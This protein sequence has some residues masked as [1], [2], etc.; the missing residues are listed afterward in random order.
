MSRS[1]IISLVLCLGVSA[2]LFGWLFSNEPLPLGSYANTAGTGDKK[3][4]KSAS[5][6]M[7]VSKNAG[8]KT[9]GPKSAEIKPAG[10]NQREVVFSV[11]RSKATALNDQPINIV[12]NPGSQKVQLQAGAGDLVVTAS[13][14][15]M[16][17][18]PSSKSELLGNYSRG[19]RFAHIRDQNGWALV[20]SLDNG[21]KGWMFKKY[22]N[23]GGG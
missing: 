19:S 16:R 22:M 3:P 1:T 6:K 11:S 2:A 8:T 13:G 17:S 18:E 9:T 12:I 4:A 14:L 15:R 7:A 20:Q 23:K 5:S 21:Q 10:Q